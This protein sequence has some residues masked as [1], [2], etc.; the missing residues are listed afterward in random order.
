M[1]EIKKVMVA[2]IANGNSVYW[3]FPT[4]GFSK[5]CIWWW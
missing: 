1:P 5:C 3:F 4:V 2:N